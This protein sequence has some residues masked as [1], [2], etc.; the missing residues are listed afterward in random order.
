[1]AIC[2]RAG[3][4]RVTIQAILS[5][6]APDRWAQVEDFLRDQIKEVQ[7]EAVADRDR[8]LGDDAK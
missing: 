6:S 8:G 7:Q 5:S 3:V 1:M 4:A 2:D